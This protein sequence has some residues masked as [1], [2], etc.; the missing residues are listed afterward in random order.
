M[1]EFITIADAAK[2]VGISDRVLRH[3]I[4]LGLLETVVV[5]KWEISGPR[6]KS[7]PK[8][9]V[10]AVR[11]ED[12][13]AYGKFLAEARK[14]NSESIERLNPPGYLGKLRKVIKGSDDVIEPTSAPIPLSESDL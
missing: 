7:I 10:S 2:V 13:I 12:A 11:L 4:R 14:L 6:K 1:T 9:D 3:H 8:D 5:K